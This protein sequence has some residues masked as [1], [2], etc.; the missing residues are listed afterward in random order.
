MCDASNF[1]YCSSSNRHIL[2]DYARNRSQIE[3][4]LRYHNMYRLREAIFMIINGGDA[5]AI[6]TSL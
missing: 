6:P 1:H 5:L 4:V 3:Q 2:N